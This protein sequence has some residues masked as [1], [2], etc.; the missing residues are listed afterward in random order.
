MVQLKRFNRCL[1]LKNVVDFVGIEGFR[2]TEHRLRPHVVLC[3]E[4]DE[5]AVP[6]IR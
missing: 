3:G 2:T 5:K 1:S 6:R 4:G